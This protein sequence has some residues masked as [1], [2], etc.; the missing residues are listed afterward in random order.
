MEVPTA[1][2]KNEFLSGNDK[3]KNQTLRQR[4]DSPQFPSDDG[5]ETERIAA[6]TCP[7]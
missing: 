2:Q 3:N 5:G 6:G 7:A 1:G 4:I